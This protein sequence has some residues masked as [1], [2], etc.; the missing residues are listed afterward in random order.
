MTDQ[1]VV[2]VT[3][4]GGFIGGRVVE[5]LHLQGDWHVKAGIHSWNGVARIA[6][7]PVE[8]VPCDVTDPA[9]VN[10]ALADVTHVVHCAIGPPAVTVAGTQNMLAAA[11]AK[12]VQRF[13]HLS[14]I[15]VYDNQLNGEITEEMP[16]V[17]NGD[18]Y[19]DSKVQAERLCWE[20]HEKGL[21]VVALRPAIV[22]GPFS[23]LWTVGVFERLASGNWGTLGGFGEGQCNLVY[24]DDVVQ[25]IQLA[26]EKHDAVGKAFN[27]IG[28]GIRTWN[29]YFR[30]F[31]DALG[32][33][34]L[35]EI[36]PSRARLASAITQPIRATAKFLL[37][38]YGQL[39]MNIYNRSTLAKKVMQQTE[40]SLK[41][42][43][44]A[45]ELNLYSRKTGYS[46]TQ[47]RQVLGYNPLTSEEQGID[48]SVQWLKH[49]GYLDG[50]IQ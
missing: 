16:V 47:A 48:L 39:I 21:P 38:R 42:T 34:P 32:F 24:I 7:F 14:T 5:K 23:K 17:A 8:I 26:L 27:I 20:H 25:A 6:R 22:Y 9:A 18:P 35:R 29:E 12:N 19:G 2:L 37:S 28:P 33:P 46:I 36:Q 50:S 4:A 40:R 43:P 30:R 3:G 15:E 31:N 11:R 10:R 41:T 44:A 13:V 49:H 1:K 45:A